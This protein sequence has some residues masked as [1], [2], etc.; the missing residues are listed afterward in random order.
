MSTSTETCADRDQQVLAFIFGEVIPSMGDFLSLLGSMFDSF[1]GFIFFAIGKLSG[2][3]S[4]PGT[5]RHNMMSIS[6]TFGFC[7]DSSQLITT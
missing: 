1:F 5:R 3:E 2:V 7:A 6:D 4:I